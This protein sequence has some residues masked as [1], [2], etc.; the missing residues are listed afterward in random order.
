[1]DGC[2]RRGCAG[3]YR[4]LPAP[5]VDPRREF[6]ADLEM[7]Q[8]LRL[9]V[10]YL[11]GPRVPSLVRPVAPNL[12]RPEPA[13]LN[14]FAPAYGLPQAVEDG[15]DQQPGSRSDYVPPLG[16]ALDQVGSGH[17]TGSTLEIGI[18]SRV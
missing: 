17:A 14:P 18:W 16:D 2:A 5:P 15:I 12:E 10:D 7:G 8:T 6:D 9:N 1:M 4:L 11:V 3:R 13:K